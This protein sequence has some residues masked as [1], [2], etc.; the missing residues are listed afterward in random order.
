M[1]KKNQLK[2][3]KKVPRKLYEKIIKFI[4]RFNDKWYMKHYVKYLKKQGMD[5]GYDDD[6]PIYIAVTASF[7][8]KD[9]SKI[10]IGKDVVISGDVRILT[11]DYSIAR[12]L[13]SINA[14]MPDEAYFLRDVYIGNNCFIGARSVLLPGTRIGDNV[15]VGAGSVVR[16]KIRENTIVIGN[17]AAEYADVREF[18]KR[19]LEKNDFLINK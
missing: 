2:N 12:A 6:W 5:I 17:P 10:H 3:I 11:H 13:E 4:G 7:D 19:H 18:A 14:D 15:I 9:F 1:M 16:G 8:G